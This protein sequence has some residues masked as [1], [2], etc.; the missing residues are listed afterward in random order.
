MELSRPS[1]LKKDDSDI[2]LAKDAAVKVKTGA[3]PLAKDAVAA[4][5]EFMVELQMV[6]DELVDLKES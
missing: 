3:D 2:K 1:Q 6:K 4:R 5:V